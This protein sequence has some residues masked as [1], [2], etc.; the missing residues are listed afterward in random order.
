[1]PT[2]KEMAGLPATE[3]SEQELA[4][5]R[6]RREKV[7]ADWVGTI[8]AEQTAAD[9]GK[10]ALEAG[11]STGAQEAIERYEREHRALSASIKAQ[12]SAKEQ[13]RLVAADEE[14]TRRAPKYRDRQA[15]AEAA[16]F[17]NLMKVGQG[18]ITRRRSTPERIPAP[19][20]IPVQFGCSDAADSDEP[21]HR[22]ERG[23]SVPGR[24]P[25]R[26]RGPAGQYRSVVPERGD[27]RRRQARPI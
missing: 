22:E 11:L 23:S 27:D 16:F 26:G 14:L 4:A 1:M 18:V 12:E 9:E 20:H 13:A 19:A 3:F 25:R 6:E 10:V 2:T 7:T 15:K 24:V 8:R 17:D 5:L 21:P